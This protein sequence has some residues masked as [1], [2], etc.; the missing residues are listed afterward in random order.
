MEHVAH[1]EAG[2][3]YDR[4]ANAFPFMNFRLKQYPWGCG[5]CNLFDS[6]WCVL[7]LLI[8][9]VGLTSATF[10]AAFRLKQWFVKGGMGCSLWRLTRGLSDSMKEKC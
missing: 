7:H 6:K 8:V 9:S 5:D 1:N 2:H 3:G 10:V 4:E